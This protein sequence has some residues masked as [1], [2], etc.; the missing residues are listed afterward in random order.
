[1]MGL[2]DVDHALRMVG[3]ELPEKSIHVTIEP[4]R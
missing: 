3:G 4:W 2:N 1:V